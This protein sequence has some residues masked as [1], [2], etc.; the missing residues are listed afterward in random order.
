[1]YKPILDKPSVYCVGSEVQEKQ[2]GST[3]GSLVHI[4]DETFLLVV[5][6]ESYRRK[7]SY[8][9]TEEFGTPEEKA[10]LPTEAPGP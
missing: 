8:E 10:A 5:C 1:M 9:Y 6:L 2:A 4:T 7:W 3:A